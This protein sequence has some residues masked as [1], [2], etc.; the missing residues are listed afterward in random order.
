METLL[1]DALKTGALEREIGWREFV[2]MDYLNE[3]YSQLDM[4]DMVVDYG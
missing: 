3:A 2:R 1:A 4:E